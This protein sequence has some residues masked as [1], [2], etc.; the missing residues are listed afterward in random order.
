M[1]KSMTEHEKLEYAKQLGVSLNELY[2]SNG[3]LS[4]PELDRRILDEERA[5][6]EERLWIIAAISAVASVISAIAAWMA[7]IKN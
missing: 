3:I 2:S 4:E 6:R 7:V 5:K 1:K